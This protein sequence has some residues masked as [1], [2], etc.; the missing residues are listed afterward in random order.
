MA[1]NLEAELR[2]RPLEAFTFHDKGLSGT[3][4]ARTH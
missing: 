2:D 3:S 1:R 4:V